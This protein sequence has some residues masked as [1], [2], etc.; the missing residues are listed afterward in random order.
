MTHEI[1]FN[2]KEK[3]SMNKYLIVLTVVVTLVMASQ[4]RGADADTL[5]DLGPLSAPGEIPKWDGT[6]WRPGHDDITSVVA[7]P[8]L[9]GGGS[10]KTV[11]VSVAF[12][13]PGSSNTVARADYVQSAI[14]PIGAVIA[15]L[16]NFSNTPTNLPSGW[17]ECNGQTL[18]DAGS[19]YNGQSIPNLNGNSGG[20]KRF[21]R[22]STTSGS[23]GGN[24]ALGNSGN[25]QARTDGSY[26]GFHNYPAGSESLLPSY[27]SVVWIMR[28]K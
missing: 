3:G 14:P 28:I 2:S 17:V 10:N 8:G 23:T 22:G 19:V 11:T 26:S 5:R 9:T 18:S 24:E 15:W 1:K 21:L 12:D 13:G 4:V 25:Y 27:Y 7:G 6:Q 16:K 20:T